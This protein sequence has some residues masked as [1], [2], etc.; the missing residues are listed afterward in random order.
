M[1]T[2]QKNIQ[3]L[4]KLLITARMMAYGVAGHIDR[5]EFNWKLRRI[6]QKHALIGCVVKDGQLIKNFDDMEALI[7]SIMMVFFKEN[8]YARRC[9]YNHE[10]EALYTGIHY[11]STVQELGSEKTFV[12]SDHLLQFVADKN[13]REK[14]NVASWRILVANECIIEHL[15]IEPLKSKNEEKEEDGNKD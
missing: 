14:R 6:D 2:K 9:A 7:D 11:P 8:I 15:K 1:V 13:R 12:E 5:N 10:V 4:E 3:K